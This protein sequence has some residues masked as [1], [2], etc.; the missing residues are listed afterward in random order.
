MLRRWFSSRGKPD[1][2]PMNFTNQDVSSMYFLVAESLTLA[3]EARD[4]SLEESQRKEIMDRWAT[5]LHD[6]PSFGHLQLYIWCILTFSTSS[7][8][9]LSDAI[10]ETQ[11]A[12]ATGVLEALNVPD[13]M[14]EQLVNML[15]PLGE[16][17]NFERIMR[18]TIFQLCEIDKENPSS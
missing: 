6:I 11:R 3:R 2:E 1:P 13:E 18:E 12:T 5:V 14:S 15:P 10:T 4:E 17:I 9:G 7:I 16:T 8:D